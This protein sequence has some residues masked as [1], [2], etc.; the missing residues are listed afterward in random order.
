MRDSSS[1]TRGGVSGS[2]GGAT[3]NTTAPTTQ[4]RSAA[5]KVRTQSDRN[6]AISPSLHNP[7]RGGLVRNKRE[8]QG[9]ENFLHFLRARNYINRF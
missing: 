1:V 6:E 9:A 7:F 4:T 2:G 3:G 8:N 5:A